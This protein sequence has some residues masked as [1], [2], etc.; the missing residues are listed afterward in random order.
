[1]ARTRR[2]S[3]TSSMKS[4]NIIVSYCVLCSGVEGFLRP[5]SR[6]LPAS[7]LLTRPQIAAITMAS[8]SSPPPPTT[9]TLY[10]GFLDDIFKDAFSNDPTLPKNGSKGSIEGPEDVLLDRSNQTP[11]LQ[12]T[13]IQR[14]WLEAQQR[15]QKQS[16]PAVGMQGQL[17]GIS[18]TI[19]TAKGAPLTID[20]LVNTDWELS[21]YLT[22]VPDRDPS[23]DLYGSKTNVSARDRSLG[24][25]ASLPPVPTAKVKV[26]LLDD[27]VVNIIE[28]S[29]AGTSTTTEEKNHDDDD[30][31]DDSAYDDGAARICPMDVPGKWKLSDDGKMMRIGIPIRGYRRTVTTTGTIQRVFWSGEEP[32]ITKTSSTYSIPEGFIYGDIGVG[33]GDRPGTLEMMKDGGGGSTTGGA[34][35]IIPGGLL[36]VE[37]RIGMLGASS[38]L[39]PCGR[40][41]GREAFR[42]FPPLGPSLRAA[43]PLFPPRSNPR[44]ND[45]AAKP[46][47]VPT[48]SEQR[49]LETVRGELVQKYIALEHSEKYATREVSYFLEDAER[50][51]QYVEMRRIA[52]ALCNDLGI[53]DVVE[54]IAAF[55]VG[56]LGSWVLNSWHTI[57]GFSC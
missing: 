44:I 38:K 31:S 56:M 50:S 55:F 17:G 46:R 45:T 34:A 27:G 29:R 20:V 12:Q 48:V 35:E 49:E 33:Y 15:Q 57:Q 5:A 6:T 37:K 2:R 30:D 13:E 16:T 11:R 39:L 53:E 7:V 9:T 42:V 52:M 23:N 36:R 10:M 8:S 32:S 1:M 54:F 22:G 14:R 28:S 47:R 4:N 51:K 26:R 40:F 43:G 24:L 21:L 18:K 3:K 25:G 41:T 19:K